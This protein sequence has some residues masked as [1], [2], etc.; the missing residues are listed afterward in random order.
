MSEI[1]IYDVIRR[2]VITEKSD[3]QSDVLNQYSFEVDKRATK[4]QI[5]EAVEIVFGVEVEKVR[6]MIVPAKRGRRLRTVVQRKSEWKKA[7]VTLAE[8]D[9]IDL[10]EM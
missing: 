10:F 7:V 6:T 5:K 3:Y 4:Q 8:G 1:H 9:K 2:P